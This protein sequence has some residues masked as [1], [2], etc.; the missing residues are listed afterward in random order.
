[1]GCDPGVTWL[2]SGFKPDNVHEGLSPECHG[3]LAHL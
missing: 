3:H 1:M 2:M